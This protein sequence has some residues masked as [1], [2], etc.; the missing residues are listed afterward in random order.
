MPHDSNI[1]EAILGA[2]FLERQ[3]IELVLNIITPGMF[4]DNRNE[5]IFNACVALDVERKP[6]D[7]LTVVDQLRKDGNL[8]AAGGAGRIADISTK[9]VS[10]VHLEYHCEVLRDKYLHR[11][12]IEVCS[13]S[14]SRGFDE[15]Q[16]IDE[17]IANLNSGIE[18][19]QGAAVGKNE[20]C[21]ISD[22]AHAALEQMHIRIA[23]RR[24]GITPG[25]P[26]GFADLNRLTNGWQPEKF[27]ILAARPGVG[28]TSLAIKFATAAAKS[29]TPVAFFS[30]EMGETE[31]VDKMII[32]EARVNA[33]D[34]NSGS[35]APEQWG[36]TDEAMRAIS[37]LPIYIDDNP[38]STVTGIA[39]KARLL[40]KQ[41]KCGMVIIDYLQLIT[42]VIRQGRTRDQ[43][44]GEISRW[45]KIYAKELKVPFIVLCQMNREID[46]ENKR[47]PRLSDLR[48]S[49][50]IE[51]DSDIVIFATR[52]GMD[53]KEV[54]DEKTGVELDNIIL[55]HLKK[56]RGGKI[57]RV[58]IKHN[59]SMTDFFDWDY[60]SVK[61]SGIPQPVD[62]SEPR[63]GF[64]SPF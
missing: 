19:L 30:L 49:G 34:Y 54:R 57:G 62:Y 60:N 38:K 32:A 21:H 22:A 47:T 39:N 58:Q 28:K 10:S 23:N 50:S 12:L 1:E 43:E 55:L 63:G 6:V 42:P 2:V 16:F 8:S 51:Q 7:I 26:T 29:G 36:K 35:I 59:D 11:R 25:I 4:Y 3:A 45:L 20:I 52:P 61:L 64:E 46:K 48:E 44:L 37:A 14:L 33:D 15:S 27:I 41:G 13:D 56:H 24:E 18:E 53:G 31:L 17:T 40:K 5:L 9:V